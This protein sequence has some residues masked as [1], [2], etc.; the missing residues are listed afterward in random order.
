VQAVRFLALTL[1]IVLSPRLAMTDVV[2]QLGHA[3]VG[4]G[5]STTQTVEPHRAA[6]HAGTTAVARDSAKGHTGTALAPSKTAKIKR[7]WG[8]PRRV[9][10]LR[11]PRSKAW[12]MISGQDGS[13]PLTP[14]LISIFSNW[15]GSS[16]LANR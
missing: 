1:A 4:T 7:G 9:A 13:C 3:K 12:E 10:L 15:S 5:A 2:G 16:G 11:R 14:L 8:S 6:S